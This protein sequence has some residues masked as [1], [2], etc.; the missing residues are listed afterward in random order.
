VSRPAPQ[1]GF[2]YIG[3]LILVAIAGVALAGAGQLWSTLAK[4]DREAQLLFVGDEFRRAIGSYYEG[5]P[6]VHQFPQ[7]L[8]DLLEDR[9]LPVVRRHLRKIYV[10]P[11]TGN[12]EWGLVKNGDVILGVHSLSKGKPLKTAN[13]KPEDAAFEGSGAYTEWV[14]T[15][16]PAAAGSASPPTGA[17]GGA[18]LGAPGSAKT[19]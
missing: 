8:D 18:Q 11:M 7:A 9:R 14:F 6:G 3:V 2:T 1:R 17:A 12:K 13:F 16:Q 4:R 15:Y 19:R 5:S 10:D